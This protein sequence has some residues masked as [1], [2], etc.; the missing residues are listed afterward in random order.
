MA[1]FLLPTLVLGGALALA[2]PAARAADPQPP[3]N[4]PPRL[5]EL[6]RDGPEKFLERYDKNKDGVLTPDEAP[7]FLK[8]AFER[9]DTNGDGKLDKEEL[10]AFYRVMRRRFGD[11]AGQGTDPADRGVAL[12]LALFDR[13]NDGKI[14]REEAGGRLADN[15]DRLDANKD[16]FLD[17][18]ELRRAA[19]VLLASQAPRPAAAR[20]LRPQAQ[21]QPAGVPDFDALDRD[22]DGRLTRDEVKGTPLADRFDQIDTNK[23]GQIDRKEFKEYLRKQVEK[24]GP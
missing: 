16:G 11:G 23:D 4:L 10:A 19:T 15:F 6:L 22:A 1:R 3:Q 20:T 13:N 8:R 2:A 9:A 12:L 24:K 7:P 18:D 14:S 5:V 21:A 17:R